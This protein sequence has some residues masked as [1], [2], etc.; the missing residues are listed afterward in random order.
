MNMNAPGGSEKAPTNRHYN[1][2]EKRDAQD[3][4]QKNHNFS[5]NQV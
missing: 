1:D 4:K 3:S 2:R 5:G